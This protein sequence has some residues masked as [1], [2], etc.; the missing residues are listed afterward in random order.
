MARPD[1]LPTLRDT[2]CVMDS[3]YEHSGGNG[4]ADHYLRK[5]GNKAIL[6]DIRGPGC[7][8]RFWS[9]NAAGHH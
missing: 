9:A 3:S 4:D 8:Y 5:E 2:K 1:L 6:S 7:I